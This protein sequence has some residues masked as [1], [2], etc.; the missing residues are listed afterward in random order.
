MI[1]GP[2]A[3]LSAGWLAAGAAACAAPIAI[4]LLKKRSRRII[5]PP[6]AL[7]APNDARR[8]K[9][10]RL[11]DVILLTLRLLALALLALAFDQPVWIGP[12]TT[13]SQSGSTCCLFSRR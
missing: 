10:R 6:A 8:D 12:S 4:H 2:I 13:G 1:L 5:F 11:Q 3:G 9:G 7:L